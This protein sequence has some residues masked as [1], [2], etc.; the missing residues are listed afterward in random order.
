MSKL[1]KQVWN[2]YIMGINVGRSNFDTI[3]R[4]FK[5]LSETYILGNYYAILLQIPHPETTLS[6]DRHDN[7]NYERFVKVRRKN[8]KR[9]SY[10]SGISSLA[11]HPIHV[12]WKR[13]F[14]TTTDQSSAFCVVGNTRLLRK[15]FFIIF[16]VYIALILAFCTRGKTHMN[17]NLSMNISHLHICICVDI[18]NHSFH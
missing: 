8:T 5:M 2:S 12:Y 3:I 6:Y 4:H 18:K 13:S 7:I 1:D 17:S 11:L 9:K 15:I 14:M 16:Y 10:L